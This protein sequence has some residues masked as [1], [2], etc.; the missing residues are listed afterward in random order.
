MKRDIRWFDFPETWKEAL[1]SIVS[2]LEYCKYDEV[3][4]E[5]KTL[6]T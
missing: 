3:R 2:F 6:E 4:E 1:P 5:V